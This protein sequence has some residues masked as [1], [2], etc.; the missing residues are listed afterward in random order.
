LYWIA[1]T[2]SLGFRSRVSLEFGIRPKLTLKLNCFNMP[3]DLQFQSQYENRELPRVNA[4]VVLMKTHSLFDRRI[5]TH[6]PLI[7]IAGQFICSIYTV[8]VKY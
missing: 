8:A 5:D 2:C 1:L 6:L 4:A 3:D 7:E